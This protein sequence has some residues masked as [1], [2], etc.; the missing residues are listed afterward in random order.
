MNYETIKEAGY[1]Y[2]S[3]NK[4]TKEHILE[5]DGRNEIFVASKNFCG[6]ALIYKNTHLEFCRSK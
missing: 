4:E 2:I 5:L 1:K 6:W 3:Y